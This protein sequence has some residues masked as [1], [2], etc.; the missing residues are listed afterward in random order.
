MP[1]LPPSST[2]PSTEPH[3]A[4]R[5][6]ESFGA[7]PE[8]YDRTR[9][10]YPQALIDR[11][12]SA[13]PGLDV[14]DVGIG[15]GISAQPFLAAGCRLL[16]VEVDARMAEFARRHGFDVEVARFEDWDAAGRT[17]DTII[18]GMTWH[19]VDPIVGAA[20][21]AELLRPGGQLALF[22]NVQQPPSELAGMFA[23]VYKRVVPGTPFA[24]TPRDPVASY[25]RLLDI[26]AAGIEASAKFGEP[27]RWRTDWER[28]Y[29]K[30]EWLEQ[31]P[32]FGGHSQFPEATLEELLAGIGTAIDRAGGSFT[33]SY[34]ALA[35]TATRT[36][37]LR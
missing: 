2:P 3:R 4:R 27:K 25:G 20:K 32:T 11:I 22:W 9:P 19:W 36:D 26:A 17:F 12:I 29:S 31:V 23:D 6:A 35:L 21:A 30:A 24:G 33:M 13:S 34:A 15:T 1:T 14:L 37:V 7:D 16:G 10:R 18:A 8:L 5:V 28:A